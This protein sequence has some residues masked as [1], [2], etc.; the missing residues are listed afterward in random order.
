M[1]ARSS[2][3]ADFAAESPSPSSKS[4]RA[5]NDAMQKAALKNGNKRGIEDTAD[6]GSSLR[7]SKRSRTSLASEFPSPAPTTSGNEII[8]DEDIDKVNGAIPVEDDSG[9]FQTGKGQRKT[10]SVAEVTEKAEVSASV[11]PN[12]R[13]RA[14]RTK[15][16]YVDQDV[17]AEIDGEVKQDQEE[18][19]EIV[20]K[21]TVKRKRKTKEE[22]EA[23]AM[24]LAARTRGLR[25]FVGAHVSAAKGVQNAVTN[26]VHIGG[27]AFALFL[28][29]Q[30]KWDNPPLQ[31]EN[32]DAFRQMCVEHQYDPAKYVLPHGSYLVNLAQ[33]DKAKAKQG[34]DSFLEDLQRCEALGI[35]L[36]NFHPGSANQSSL[37]SALSR[38]AD[39]LTNALSATKTVMPVLETMCGHGTTI[40]GNLSDFRDL[41]ALIPEKYHDRIGICVDTCHS[42]AAGYDLVSPAGF[43]DFMKEFDDLIGIKYLRA[44]H[45][46]DSKAPRGS[47]RD[48]HANIGTG[49]LGLRAF[50][51]VMNEK[52]FEGLPMILETPIDRP[53][54]SYLPTND[55]EANEEPAHDSCAE[56]SEAEDTKARKG[57]KSKRPA[58]AR[59][60]TI[61]D[62]NV[63]AREIKLL[64][65]LIGMD[66]ESA[67]FKALEA[68]LAEEGRSE[69]EK[70]QDQYDRKLEA[71]EKKRK[72]ELEKQN[73]R[74][75][76]DM[77]GAGNAKKGTG[78][79]AKAA[80]KKERGRKVKSK[81]ERDSE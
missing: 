52:R 31:D 53:D 17:D 3:N 34:Y 76:E 38:L 2:R 71:D 32:R 54:P 81:S 46:N 50:H 24:P 28:K 21:K 15:A 26:S 9:K 33:E 35:K 44:L 8:P 39:A 65:S 37:S 69:R 64:E 22:K 4:S 51:N 41:L 59:P 16:S 57:K 7:R 6:V 10:K 78:K 13:G 25:M 61:P 55:T 68:Q 75:L 43:Q 42:F 66:P 20:V 27:N 73:Q 58:G 48:L 14:A 72:K 77:F 63:W 47:K 12:K 60:P 18:E 5:P 70:L 62:Y 29:S 56:E 40:G 45:L 23:E 19:K 74:S 36:Y 1:P 67:E 79:A 11:K 49:F 30:R 80:P